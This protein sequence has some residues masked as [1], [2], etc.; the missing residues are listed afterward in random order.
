[1]EKKEYSIEIGGKRLS[2]LFTDLAD[3]AHGSVI[4]SYEDTALLATAVMSKNPKEGDFFPLVVDYEERFYAGGKIGGSRFV[5]REGRPSDE[6]ILSGRIIDRTIRPLFDQH[7]RH[8]V[9]V[10]ITVLA[11]GKGDPDALGVIAASLA[12][13]TSRIPWNGPA[14]CAK[15]CRSKGSTEFIVNPSWMTRD[16]ESIEFEL[17]ACGKDGSINMIE[18]GARETSEEDLTAALQKASETIEKIQEFQKTVIAE[19]GAT[20]TVIPKPEIPA[21]LIELFENDFAA[22]LP[23]AIFSGPGK[24]AIGLLEDE[25][26]EAVREKLP[27]TVSFGDALFE[28]RTNKVIHDEAIENERRADGR[29]MDEIRPLF[30]QAGGVSSMLHGS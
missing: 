3:Q 30:V 18:I 24:A 6:A 27:E 14:S 25:W 17:L 9:Q 2:A 13:G 16:D 15:I 19:R 29:K 22:R 28:E 26:M 12:I 4:V 8:E 23:Q 20:K 1:M 21:K 11:L 10:V 5:R 7:I